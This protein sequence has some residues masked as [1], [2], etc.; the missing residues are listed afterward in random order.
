MQIFI[1]NIWNSKQLFSECWI[2]TKWWWGILKNN[3]MLERQCIST[4][5]KGGKR[6]NTCQGIQH[7]IGAWCFTG[8]RKKIVSRDFNRE[9][10]VEIPKFHFNSFMSWH[11]ETRKWI[12]KIR[13]YSSMV[14]H[15][16]IKNR[17]GWIIHQLSIIRSLTL[18]RISFN[19][20]NTLKCIDLV[21]YANNSHEESHYSRE[22]DINNICSV[23]FCSA[24]VLHLVFLVV[25]ILSSRTDSCS[26]FIALPWNTELIWLCSQRNHSNSKCSRK[27]ENKLEMD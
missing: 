12:N 23:R 10:C 26:Q 8:N 6:K 15:L 24:V 4:L 2:H 11:H 5:N 21:D 20:W 3:V 18:I 7:G 19:R 1:C 16:A 13:Y 17:N 22:N 25:H 9:Y 14:K 27:K